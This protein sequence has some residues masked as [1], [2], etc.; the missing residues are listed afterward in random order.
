MEISQT[1]AAPSPA[2]PP[3]TGRGEKL[4]QILLFLLAIVPIGYIGWLIFK[5]GV[6]ILYV[7]DWGYIFLFHDLATHTLNF[8]DLIAQHNESRPLLPVLIILG[9]ASQTHWDVRWEMWIE[10]GFACLVSINIYLLSRRLTGMSRTQRLF[11]WVITNVLLFSAEQVAE[12]DV[13]NPDDLF[14]ADALHLGGHAGGVL[15][16]ERDVEI[17]AVRSS[18]DGGDFFPCDR[19]GRMDRLASTVIRRIARTIPAIRARAD[20][21]GDCLRGKPMAVLPRLL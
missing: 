8:H 18:G 20:H 13:R 11:L 6:N 5:T 7:D 9:V 1:R 15:K 2:L 21:V 19:A 14:H 10:L 17:R 4:V 16:M 12:L 3:T